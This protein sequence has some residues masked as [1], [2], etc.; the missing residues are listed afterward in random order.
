MRT[1]RMERMANYCILLLMLLLSSKRTFA[2][3]E[4]RYNDKRVSG[5]GAKSKC[6]PAP[7]KVCKEFTYK[8]IKKY[9][10]LYFVAMR[11]WALDDEMED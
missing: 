11:C 4:R 2:D 3:D 10:C 8:E 6:Y 5:G 9:Y 1:E 7:Q